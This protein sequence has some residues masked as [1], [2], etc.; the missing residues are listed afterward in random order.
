MQEIMK[1]NKQRI[2]NWLFVVSNGLLVIVVVGVVAV[3]H[4]IFAAAVVALAVAVLAVLRL[5]IGA[6]DGAFFV[7]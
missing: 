5:T 7:L 6:A 2:K 3:A 4:A 1:Y